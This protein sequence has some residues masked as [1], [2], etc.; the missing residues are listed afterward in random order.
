MGH[1][2]RAGGSLRQQVYDEL[3]KKNGFGR[4]KHADKKAGISGQYIYS[5]NSMKTY[6]K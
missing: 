6:L 2:N 5:F 1:R 3:Q 4:S